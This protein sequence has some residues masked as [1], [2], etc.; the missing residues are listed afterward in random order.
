[1][2]TNLVF[3]GW[4]MNII[5]YLWIVDSANAFLERNMC[6]HSWLKKNMSL[7]PLLANLIY[8]ISLC[9][10]TILLWIKL[11]AYI[12]YVFLSII[13]VILL[14]FFLLLFNNLS[15]LT[16]LLSLIFL[17]DRCIWTKVGT[18]IFCSKIWRNLF[19]PKVNARNIESIICG[20]RIMTVLDIGML[21]Y[22][23]CKWILVVYGQISSP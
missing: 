8:K 3:P 9:W 11:L 15:S 23:T 14:N 13:S 2:L 7:F 22:C 19:D 16:A 10:L 12:Y 21:I 1:M 4:I 6:T 5:R 20:M 17:I 18:L